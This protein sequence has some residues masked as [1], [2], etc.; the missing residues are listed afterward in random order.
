MS[1][2]Y[3]ASNKIISVDDV[4][5]APQ[6][7]RFE[8]DDLESYCQSLQ[9]II[10]NYNLDVS[11]FF[12]PN[13]I[14]IIKQSGGN[15]VV[16]NPRV[17]TININFSDVNDKFLTYYQQ[18]ALAGAKFDRDRNN[19]GLPKK[20][21]FFYPKDGSYS[22]TLNPFKFFGLL[23]YCLNNPVQLETN[24]M[25]QERNKLE[26]EYNNN[27]KYIEPKK[28]PFW[29]FWAGKKSR[30]SKRSK[31]SRKSRKSRRSRK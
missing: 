16:T 30:K 29:K 27:N 1:V 14:E 6:Q 17:T 10:S 7:P 28:K 18:I 12:S 5:Q 24:E 19:N 13:E 23:K 3:S 31:K 25:I 4:S 9:S 20:M 2:I 26:Q 15:N 22:P 8:T 11:K 21:G